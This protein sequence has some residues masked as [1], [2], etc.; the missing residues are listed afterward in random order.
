VLAG[1]E[2]EDVPLVPPN[3]RLELDDVYVNEKSKL[4]IVNV[5]KYM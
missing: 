3:N 4:C 5:V 2:P 1:R